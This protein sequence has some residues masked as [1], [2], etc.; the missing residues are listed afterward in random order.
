[1]CMSACLNVF[2]CVI[3]VLSAL[4]GWKGTSDP[5]QLELSTTVNCHCGAGNQTDSFARATNF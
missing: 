4:G 2:I 5:L 1:M 3:S